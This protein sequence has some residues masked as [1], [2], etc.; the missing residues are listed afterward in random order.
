V[1]NLSYIPHLIIGL[2]LLGLAGAMGAIGVW[3]GSDVLTISV[4]V[5]IGAGVLSGVA[6]ASGT[7]TT[8]TT[9]TTTPPG[10]QPGPVSGG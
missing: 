3:T 7:V 1:S 10:P 5:G 8:N 6:A 9:T 2:A 4:G